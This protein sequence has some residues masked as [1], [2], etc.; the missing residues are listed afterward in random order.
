VNLREQTTEA[1]VDLRVAIARL[2]HVDRMALTGAFAALG[3]RDNAKGLAEL[4]EALSVL[5]GGSPLERP[6]DVAAVAARMARPERY[7]VA[8]AYAEARDQ[9]PGKPITGFY[10]ALVGL[11]CH[12]EFEQEAA[13]QAFADQLTDPGQFGAGPD[14]PGPEAA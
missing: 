9:E 6:P 11:L 12:V 3:Q 1:V 4:Y 14:E 8:A 5:C 2:S 7:A 10:S 13:V